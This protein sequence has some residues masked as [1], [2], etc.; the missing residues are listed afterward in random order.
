MADAVGKVEGRYHPA[1]LCVVKGEII[2]DER[3]E[4]LEESS[5][6]VMAEVR[7]DKEGQQTPDKGE[8]PWLLDGKLL[9]SYV[10]GKLA[11]WRRG[12]DS[13]PR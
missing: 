10:F 6:E 4:G 7:Q 9:S 12:W 5:G 1:C 13:N 3:H 11:S 8:K 2:A